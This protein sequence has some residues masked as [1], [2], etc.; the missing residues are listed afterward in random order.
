M[1]QV[2][3]NHKKLN[4]KDCYFYLQCTRRFWQQKMPENLSQIFSDTKRQ[5]VEEKGK[6]PGSCSWRIGDRDSRLTLKSGG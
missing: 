2:T 4:N 3:S 6:M 5:K 1:G